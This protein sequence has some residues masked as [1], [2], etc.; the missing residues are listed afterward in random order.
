MPVSASSFL[1]ATEDPFLRKRQKFLAVNTEKTALPRA[2]GEYGVFHTA[3]A[4]VEVAA[5]VVAVAD[6]PFAANMGSVAS[7]HSAGYKSQDVLEDDLRHRDVHWDAGTL[8]PGRLGCKADWRRNWA[9][10]QVS[11]SGRHSAASWKEACGKVGSE[12]RS[13]WRASTWW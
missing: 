2:S 3:A 7:S 8:R 6:T 1:Q 13:I 10:K 12:V 4:V 9:Q 11:S 5:V